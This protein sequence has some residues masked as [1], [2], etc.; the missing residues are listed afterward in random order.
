[1]RFESRRTSLTILLLPFLL[2]FL[3]PVVSSS[4]SQ[5]GE[6]GLTPWDLWD[7]EDEGKY[8][9]CEFD[10][11]DNTVCEYVFPW[12]DKD[13]RIL[14]FKEYHTYTTMKDR[15]MVLARDNPDIF[16]FHEGLNGG[17]NARG[18]ETTA[19][20]YEGWHYGHSSPW[21]KITGDVQGGEYNPFNGDNGNYADRPD[22]MIVGNH[23]AREWICLLYT[24]D[25]AD[26]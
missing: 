9:Y 17:T 20:T 11:N 1:M 14:Q 19:D 6:E 8:I 10:E 26:E 22:I 23:H 3:S 13:N 16:E 7:Q 18:E 21:L 12:S 4:Y 5:T 25:A 24:S 15:M 2:S